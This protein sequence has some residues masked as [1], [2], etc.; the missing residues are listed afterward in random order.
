MLRRGIQ[1][2]EEVT[3][4]ERQTKQTQEQ[5]GLLFRCYI[6]DIARQFEFVQ[7]NWCNNTD[8]VQR[9]A[10]HDP[11]IGQVAGGSAR[12]FAGVG[13]A[14]LK[15]TFDFKPWVIMTGGVYLFAP[16]LDFIRSLKAVS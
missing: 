8:F 6:T 1:F 7:K 14:G 11:I 12:T 2:G 3:E 15:P 5:R 13:Y 10:G 9:A 4:Q 16:S